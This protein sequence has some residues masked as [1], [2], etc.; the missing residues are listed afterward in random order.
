L[1]A[2]IIQGESF[3]SYFDIN[4]R[5][6]NKIQK[7]YKSKRERHILL[8]DDQILNLEALKSIL[9][10]KFKFEVEKVCRLAMNG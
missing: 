5:D 2:S 9:K 1:S 7:I 10:H 4:Y 3:S 8:V 6:V